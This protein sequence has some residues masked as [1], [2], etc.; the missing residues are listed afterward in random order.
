MDS[1]KKKLGQNSREVETA[2]Q[3]NRKKIVKMMAELWNKTEDKSKAITK[4]KT[5]LE[6]V[7]RMYD[8]KR[9]HNNLEC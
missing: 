3:K 8:E 7:S 2:E 9:S 5:T 4:I 6:A 1:K